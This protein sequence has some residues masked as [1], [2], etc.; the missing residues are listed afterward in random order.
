MKKIPLRNKEGKILKYTIIDDDDFERV[1]K[2]SWCIEKS[3]SYIYANSRINYKMVMLHRFIMNCPK[4]KIVDHKNMN[5]LDNRKC[6]LRICTKSQNQMNRGKTKNNTTGFKG[7]IF[8][9]EKDKFIARITKDKKV[10]RLGSFNTVEEAARV[11]DNYAIK[12]HGEFAYL[13]FPL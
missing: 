3:R 9:K 2:H 6:N 8:N 7:V 5:T 13:N 1:S 10:F 4:D 11:Y 12:L